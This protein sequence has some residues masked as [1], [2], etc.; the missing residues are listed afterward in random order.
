MRSFARSLALLAGLALFLGLL[1]SCNTTQADPSPVASLAAGVETTPTTH[2]PGQITPTPILTLGPIP[3]PIPPTVTPAASP[4]PAPQAIWL[5]ESAPFD[6]HQAVLDLSARQPQDYV[7]VQEPSDATIRLSSE[8]NDAPFKATWVYALVAPFPTYTDVVSGSD[9]RGTWRGA[10]AGPFVEHPLIAS[11]ETLAVLSGAWG[12]PAPGTVTPLPAEGL[13]RRAWAERAVWA[14]LPFDE[15]DPRWKVIKVD[16]LSPLDQNLDL[17]AYPL[18]AH[19]GATGPEEALATFLVDSNLPTTNRDEDRMTVVVMT[20]VTALTRAT[21]WRMESNGLTYPARDIGDWLHEADI[22]HV[23]SEVSFDPECGPPDPVQ[24]GLLFCSD[25]RYIE[26]LEHIEVDVVEMTGNHIGDAGVEHITPT[27]QMYRER[28]WEY[29]GGGVDLQDARQARVFYHNGNAI[30]FVGCNAAG[31]PS[32]WATG[33]RPGAAP[34]GDYEFLYQQIAHMRADGILPIVT[35]QY[36]EFDSYAPTPQQVEDFTNLV[37][38]GAV[39]VSGSQAHHA[40]GLGF[41][42]PPPEAW[43]PEVGGFIDYGLGNL[44][45]DQHQMLGYRQEFIDRHVFYAGRHVSTELLTAFLE[46]WSKPRPMTP[47]ERLALL[48]AAFEASGW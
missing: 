38:A 17:N 40:Q 29:F 5:D 33:E 37:K 39:I 46:D 19:P 23:S 6:W 12:P 31:P 2:P 44:F 24:E 4:T 8:A 47:E 22:T 7:L 3:S 36:W 28:G 45:F 18:V 10:P 26:L 9:L 15:L 41:Y 11:E 21:A 30:G 34:C 27:L 16:G 48:Q 43:S 35:L 20:G 13:L 42:P 1:S 14:I 32:V 25:P